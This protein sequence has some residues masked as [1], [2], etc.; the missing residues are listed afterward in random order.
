MSNKIYLLVMAL[1]ILVALLFGMSRHIENREY[2]RERDQRSVAQ[3]GVSAEDY[4]SAV[5]IP[6]QALSAAVELVGNGRE[7]IPADELYGEASAVRAAAIKAVEAAFSKAPCPANRRELSDSARTVIDL[8][9]KKML[10]DVDKLEAAYFMVAKLRRSK[11][12]AIGD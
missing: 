11:C 7:V 4:Q 10:A 1:G 6:A 2:L 9:P 8:F 12:G 3:F 5:K